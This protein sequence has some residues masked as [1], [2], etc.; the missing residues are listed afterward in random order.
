MGIGAYECNAIVSALLSKGCVLA[1]ETVA[2]VD[3]G[4]IVKL[5]DADDLVLGQVS[6]HWCEFGW[7]SDLIRL[8]SL[9]IVI[10]KIDI[11]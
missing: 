10:S 2:G 9:R 7:I 5:G 1:E 4:D 3:H 8:V 11:E 6:A